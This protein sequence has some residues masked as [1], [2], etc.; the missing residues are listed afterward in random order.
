MFRT[1]IVL[2]DDAAKPLIDALAVAAGVE[3]RDSSPTPALTRRMSMVVDDA[4][5]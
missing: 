5:G 2:P 1:L 3:V 4:T